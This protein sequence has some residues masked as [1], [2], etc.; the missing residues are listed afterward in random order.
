MN[1]NTDNTEARSVASKPPAQPRANPRK[2]ATA[3]RKQSAHES[4][5]ARS[6]AAG[7]SSAARAPGATSSRAKPGPA[8]SSVPTTEQRQQMIAEAAYLRAEQRGFTGASAMDDWLAAE[9][10][11]D[12]RYPAGS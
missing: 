12:R 2:P 9:A 1:E 10:D 3:A 7:K 4:S 11:V 6:L 5:Q 8:A